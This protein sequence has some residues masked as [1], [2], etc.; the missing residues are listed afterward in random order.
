M[1][2]RLNPRVFLKHIIYYKS[3]DIGYIQLVSYMIGSKG[4][5]VPHLEYKI[6]DKEYRNKGIMSKQLPCYI[7]KYCKKDY[8]QLLAVVKKDNLISIGILEKNGFVKFS[9]FKNEYTYIT[10]LNLK[11]DDIKKTLKEFR[12]E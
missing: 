4:R 12:K 3:K 7:N 1:E 8:P 6:V 11:I 10:D 2:T 5:N 9:E